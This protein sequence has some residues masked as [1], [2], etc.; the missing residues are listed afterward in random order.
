M[1]QE[2]VLFKI[3]FFISIYGLISSSESIYRKYSYSKNGIFSWEVYSLQFNQI[4]N[5]TVIKSLSKFFCYPNVQFFHWFRFFASLSLIT[6]II[7]IKQIFTP[8]LILYTLVTLLL[9]LRNRY[10]NDGADQMALIISVSLSLSLLMNDINCIKYAIFFVAFQGILAYTTSG[11]AK[12]SSQK[13]RNGS[14]LKL[15]INTKTYGNKFW[16]VIF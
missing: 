16:V 4:F 14:G 5:K 7:F 12:L 10:G 3:T 15:L 2:E 11:F 13:W 8:I 6:S 1:S 9:S